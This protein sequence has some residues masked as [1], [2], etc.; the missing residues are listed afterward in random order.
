[1]VVLLA[2]ADYSLRTS[3][4]G[5]DFLGGVTATEESRQAIDEKR[6]YERL[7]AANEEYSRVQAEAFDREAAA[8]RSEVEDIEVV[9]IPAPE[10]D[11]VSAGRKALVV[12]N[13]L[14]IGVIS[15]LIF[16]QRRM[17]RSEG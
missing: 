5:V 7:R 14:V 3:L 1:P 17:K 6:L 16:R 8:A 4:S 12:G 13:L 10:L 11:E 15:V 9:P 2:Y